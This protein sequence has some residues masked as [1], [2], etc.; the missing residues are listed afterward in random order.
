MK[1]EHEIKRLDRT[2]VIFILKGVLIGAIAGIVVSL[3]R[4][5]IEEIMDHL[6]TL[7]LWFNDNPFWLIPWVLVM[8]VCALVVGLLIKSEPNIKGSGIPQVEGH[9]KVRLN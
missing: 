6:V 9:Y 1:N 4:L 8:L 2:K 3:F 5:F 7:Y